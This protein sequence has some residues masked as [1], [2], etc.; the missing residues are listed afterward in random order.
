M[1]THEVEKGGSLQRSQGL[2]AY[3]KIVCSLL[4]MSWINP[5]PSGGCLGS[6]DFLHWTGTWR[7]LTGW[8][9][10]QIV[11]GFLER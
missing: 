9:E 8:K 6:S 5:H 10:A 4:E 1:D 3:V 2:H 11:S 7:L